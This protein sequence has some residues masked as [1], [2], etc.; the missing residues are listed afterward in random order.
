MFKQKRAK[1]NIIT[2]VFV[3]SLLSTQHYGER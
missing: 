3:I 1:S 2:F